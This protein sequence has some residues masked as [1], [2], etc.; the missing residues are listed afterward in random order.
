MSNLLPLPFKRTLPSDE[1]A[2]TLLDYVANSDLSTTAP[3]LIRPDCERLERSRREVYGQDGTPLV[4]LEAVEKLAGPAFS[5]SSIFASSTSSAPGSLP[6][7]I[8]TSS[9]TTRRSLEYELVSTLYNLA[10]L[11]THLALSH[12]TANQDVN[13]GGEALKLSL[14]QLQL[15]LGTL[16][17]VSHLL[18]KHAARQDESRDVEP[19]D[20][21]LEQMQGWSLIVKGMAQEVGWQ[22]AVMDRLKNGTIS[23]LACQEWN[24][25]LTIKIAHFSAVAQYR[26]SLD[27]LGSNRYGDE[28]GRLT[29]AS[30]VLKT[31]LST[32]SFAI[33]K[34]S[35]VESVTRDSKGFLKVLEDNLKRANKDNDLIYLAHPTPTSSLPQIVP[36]PLVKPTYLDLVHH[37]LAYASN[38][39]RVFEQMDKK[40]VGMALHVW[41]DRKLDWI[42]T[43]VERNWAKRLDQELNGTFDSLNLPGALEQTSASPRQQPLTSASSTTSLTSATSTSNV[44]SHL[45]DQSLEVRN[46]GG[47]ERLEL[48][49][50][51]VQKLGQLNTNIL[52]E[53]RE[54]LRNEQTS[55][56]FYRSVHGQQTWDTQFQQQAQTRS[57]SPSNSTDQPTQVQASLEQRLEHFEHLLNSAKQSDAVVRQK[58]STPTDLVEQIKRLESGEFESFLPRSQSERPGTSSRRA[59]ATDAEEEPVESLELRKTRRKMKALVEELKDIQL[60]R[61][62]LVRLIRQRV[63]HRDIKVK[64]LARS[65]ELDR[66]REASQPER[67][68]SAIAGNLLQLFEPVLEEEL[69][70]LKRE[71]QGEMQMNEKNQSD[72]L[73]SVKTLNSTFTNLLQTRDKSLSTSTSPLNPS[74]KPDLARQ[75]ALQSLSLAHHRF[76][77]MLGN[78][79]EGLK[80]YADL[81]RLTSELR[82]ETK[83]FAYSR[84]LQAQALDQQLVSNQQAQQEPPSIA[85]LDQEVNGQEEQEEEEEEEETIDPISEALSRPIASSIRSTPRRSTRN[86]P[87]TGTPL[88]EEPVVKTPKKTKE[89]Q[90]DKSRDEG[91]SSTPRT[92]GWDP[93]MGIRFG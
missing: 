54:C 6:S 28:I 56:E 65:K 9:T 78:L 4:S 57:D 86:Q 20:R 38:Q 89:K 13:S 91:S 25:Y 62:E 87:K 1:F 71:F 16:E 30:T 5:Y 7:P 41:N 68:D 67:D 83:S 17:R 29:L 52:Q 69:N 42:E 80:F 82:D 8:S 55:Q 79:E 40:E 45:L 26:R 88:K 21:D 74:A 93:S 58:Y 15:A 2:A 27:D 39:S 77:E 61:K 64:V 35:V 37:P 75:E 12:R 47:H 90:K 14:N 23:K 34:G 33:A 3:T 81:S 22:K 84:T 19:R 76:V 36:F 53:A 18:S 11:Y 31:A 73:D 63:Q 51:D 43:Q 10:A 46:L 44:P 66:A 59:Q 24:R 72:L 50:K 49:F 85:P 60:E 48:L 70:K 92:G 32:S